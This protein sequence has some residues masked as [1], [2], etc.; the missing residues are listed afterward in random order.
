MTAILIIVGISFLLAEI[1][2]GTKAKRTKRELANQKAEQARIK[3]EQ[4]AHTEW[5]RE[6]ERI[7]REAFRERLALRKEQERQAKEQERQAKELARHEEMLLRTDN[8]LAVIEGEI[9]HNREIVDRIAKLIQLE[10]SEQSKCTKDSTEWAKHEKKI[11]SLMNQQYNAQ[12]KITKAKGDRRVC[13]QK[14]SA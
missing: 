12:K 1:A 4:K 2:N 7:N 3:A 5:M 14:I 9:A 6:Q 10:E 13:E 8:R 11:V